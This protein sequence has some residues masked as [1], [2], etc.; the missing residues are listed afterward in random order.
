MP[1][2]IRELIIKAVI[3]SDSFEQE[4]CS[5]DSDSADQETSTS[6]S[7]TSQYE[8]SD[9]CSLSERENVI[10]AICADQVM[11]ILERKKER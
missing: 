11:K 10:V 7:N 4:D 8:S 3:S 6:G 1:I 5:S 9:K 2:E